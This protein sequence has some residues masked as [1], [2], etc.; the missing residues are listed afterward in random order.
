MRLR[1]VALAMIVF[2]Q[3]CGAGMSAQVRAPSISQQ[4]A[5]IAARRNAEADERLRQQFGALVG[6]VSPSTYAMFVKWER[7]V[8]A[9]EKESGHGPSAALAAGVLYDCASRLRNVWP[10]R[11]RDSDTT[12]VWDVVENRRKLAVAYFD[13]AMVDQDFVE[14]RLRRAMLMPA[15]D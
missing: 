9:W 5:D 6:Y 8:L 10:P 3:P 2:V 11:L 1:V 13:K 12:L 4:E 7:T 14:A 15:G